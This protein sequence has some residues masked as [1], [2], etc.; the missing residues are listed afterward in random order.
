VDEGAGSITEL[1]IDTVAPEPL[2]GGEM[3]GA[4]ISKPVVSIFVMT[5]ELIVSVPTK[6]DPK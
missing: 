3:S 6:V 4:N 5:D 2:T 1:Y